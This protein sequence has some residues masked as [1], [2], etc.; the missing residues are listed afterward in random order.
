MDGYYI[1]SEAIGKM[2]NMSRLQ[3]SLDKNEKKMK[4]LKKKHGPTVTYTSKEAMKLAKKI[5]D[6]RQKISSGNF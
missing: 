2:F 3:K 6:I 4:A 5:R 1:I